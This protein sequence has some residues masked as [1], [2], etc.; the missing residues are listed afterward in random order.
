MAAPDQIAAQLLQHLGGAENVAGVEQC[1]TRMRVTP[2]DRARIDESAVR[3]TD[4]VLGIVDDETFQIVL[5]PGAVTRITTAFRARL[6][7]GGSDAQ[8]LAARGA[9]I[10]AAQRRRNDTP[11]KNLIRKIANIF[12]PLIPALIGAGIVAAVRGLLVNWDAVGAAPAWVAGLIPA[13][14]AIG[15]AFFAYLAIFAGIN[16]AKEFGGTPAL[17]GAVA[18]IIVFPGIADVTYALPVVGEI[19][20]APGQ[21]G[22]IG[23]IFAAVLASW[24]ERGLRGRIPDAIDILVTPTLALLGSG[25]ATIFAFMPLAGAIATGIGSGAVWLLQVSGILAGFVLGG[26]FLPLVMLGLHQALIPI[27]ATLIEQLGFTP[28]LTILAMA[29]AGQV[30]A[31]IAIWIRLRR[32]ASLRRAI[33]GALPVGVLGVGEPLIYAVTLPLGRPFL[34][35]CL[36]GA[37]GGA[38]AGAFNQLVAP[39]GAT[40]IGPSGW[41]LLPLLQSDAGQGY[42]ILAYAIGLLAGYVGGFVIT[43]LFGFPKALLAEHGGAVDADA[44]SA[45]A[46]PSTSP[47]PGTRIAIAAPAEGRI[48]S[49]DDVPDAAFRERTLGDGFAVDPTSGRFASPVAGTITALFPTGHAFGVTTPE[50]LEVLVHVGLGTVAL[51]GEGFTVLRAEG[52]VVEAGD[53]VVDVDL[54]AIRDRVPSLVSPVVVLNGGA[55]AIVERDA[56]APVVVAASAAADA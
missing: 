24:I 45:A 19:T 25:L 54:D 10:K 50:G 43:M 35:A 15:S 12:V 38:V 16:A 55:W 34:T 6:S 52:D 51:G 14:T 20:L 42:A 11:F 29:G 17:G 40:A 13:L 32:N 48:L 56:E 4:G 33:K 5:G 2:V 27:H 46:T 47:T 49:L 41:A 37:V 28:L 18:A 7:A 30:G 44:E 23:A 3:G 21:G 8:A 36:G 31:A 53:A 39:W 26:L 9:D 22:V 1:M